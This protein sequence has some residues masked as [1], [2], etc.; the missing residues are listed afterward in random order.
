MTIDTEG[1]NQW[2]HGR[3]L[4][5]E[6][7]KYVP[8]FQDLCDKYQIIPTYLVTSEIC[9]DAFAKEIFKDYSVK[10]KAEIGA[11][12]HSWTT[13]PFRD[14]EGLRYNDKNHVYAHE[15]P[16]DLIVEKIQS[17]TSLIESS[18]GK[19]PRSFRSGRYGFN[20]T[21]ARILAENAYLVDSSVTPFINW[22]ANQGMPG[23]LG[24]PD[25][26]KSTPFPYWYSFGNS[27]L[28]EI[29]ITILP[30]RFPLNKSW[31]M[32]RYYLVHAENSLML[33]VL[34]KL[35]FS[36][37]PLWLRPHLWMDNRML[38]QLINEAIKI[39]LP[40]IVMMFHSSELMP[41]GSIY[42]TDRGDVEKLY[43]LLESF[44]ITLRE[45]KIESVSLTGAVKSY[46]A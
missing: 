42:R 44:F 26:S 38:A 11:H 12:L 32:T 33:K 8:R 45:K 30:T 7:I 34:R 10:E 36:N 4:T 13:P 40:H 15:L 25:F 14:A 6:N 3:D 16:E 31:K 21:V 17:L 41:G 20:N 18:V 28:L 2:D 29:P 19:R 23:G 43:D 35:I 37:Q 24:G 46:K 1:D 39:K 27:S 5:V 9:E 22:S